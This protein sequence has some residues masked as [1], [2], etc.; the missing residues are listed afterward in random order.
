MI[1]NNTYRLR[2]GLFS[3]NF[4]KNL[5]INQVRRFKVKKYKRNKSCYFMKIVIACW[6]VIHCIVVLS[7]FMEDPFKPSEKVDNNFFARYLHGNIQ[8]Q[9]QKGIINMHLNVRSLRY[10]VNEIK[11]LVQVHSPHI[12]G[13]SEAE[14]TKNSVKE[15][16]LKI[17]GYI[18]YFPKSWSKYGYARVVVYVR[19]SFKCVQVSELEDDK[20]QS[21]WLKGGYAKSKEIFFCHAYREHLSN[22]GSREQQIYLETFLDQWDAACYYGG[23]SEANE[24]HVCGDINID[25]Y[26]GKWLQPNYPLL[27][28][29][30]LIKNFCHANN[31]HQLVENVTRVQYNSVSDITELSCI[32]HVYTNTRF[33]C[34]SPTVI[35]FGDSDHDLVRYIRYSKNPVK[36]T[37]TL[38]TR[39]YKKFKR[40]DFI[41]DVANVDWQDVYSCRDVDSAVEVFTNKF[42]YILNNHA[43][44]VN[45]QQKQNY[46]PWITEETKI[47]MKTRDYWKQV[48]KG[49]PIGSSD[50]I[51]AWQQFKIFRNKVN[52]RKKYE[53]CQ[54]K[55]E[56]M[57]EVSD[58]PDLLWKN[59][60]TF[61]GWTSQGPPQQIQVDNVL[62][63][64]ARKMSQCMN[65]YFVGKV[66]KIRAGMIDAPFPISNL[67][68]FM[69]G[70][71]CK[72]QLRH[73]TLNKVKKILKSL[74]NSRS[75]GVDELDNFSLKIAA[76]FVSQPI[77]HII[78]LSII[79]NKFP[80]NWKFSKV[81]PL[82]KKG[83][84]TDRKNYRPVAIL[85]P[86]SKVVEKI[87][88]EQIYDF[89]TRNKLFHPNLHGYRRNRS[90]QT[91]LLQAYDRWIR[92]A[93]E[94]KLSGV[95]MLDLSAAFDLV[96]AN[97]LLRKLK[98][99]GF[100]SD[101]C[102]WLKSYL[103]NRYQA[104]WIDHVLSD[105]LQCEAGVPQ[106]SNLG[107]LLFLI[108]FNDL[109]LSLNCAF[110]GYADDSTISVSGTTVEEIS[111]NLTENCTTVSNWMKG[112]KLKLNADKTHLLTVGTEARL[113]IQDSCVEVHMDGIKLT[114]SEDRK[115]MLL[116]CYISSNLK[117][118]KNVDYV[119][120]K[121]QLRLTAIRN[122]G[123]K[124]PFGIKC[125]IAEGM[126]TSVLTY[127]LPVFGG[128]NKSDIESLQ[129]MQN[130]AARFVT[131]SEK[132]ANRQEMFL[133]IGWLTVRQLI[134]Y[135]TALCIFRIRDSQEP[136]YL[137]DI[138][139]RN[140]RAN[141]II[142][143]NTC[144]S[145]AKKSFCF[146]G[147]EDWNRLPESVR[148]SKSIGQ[149]KS[150][151]KSWIFRNVAPFGEA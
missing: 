108:F 45:F 137:S 128:C 97:L 77:H 61:M 109:P 113:R 55:A 83:E 115:E 68:D 42:R 91:A 133:Q 123:N 47:L 4:T 130:S 23:K 105:F 147:A 87:V 101:I 38:R 3:L 136:E 7:V 67:K 99:Y 76:D 16:D 107:P 37:R 79:Q 138:L 72:M 132:R 84:K 96:D 40:V 129:I 78:C 135:H 122:L 75:T 18:L 14:L 66:N 41:Q 94:G 119:M 141:K 111:T 49:H 58:S 118:Q 106:G 59:A 9:N 48:A 25:V 31:F 6:V 36:P 93:I 12:F 56:K 143:P 65:E 29:S 52:N 44:W 116:G 102:A 140:N 2:I 19:K 34:S 60:K 149:F 144:L 117:W 80:D 146:R 124:I 150:R 112:N 121:L 70:R 85:S 126:F 95:V 81:I 125:K 11:N 54:Y 43:P 73:V 53:E 134:Q 21:V 103:V 69:S 88:Y 51:E 71:N 110:D 74:S 63:T 27:P 92:A 30:K 90:T 15:E 13:V 98:I 114:E 57:M 104:V 8:N 24:T 148:S 46:Q 62:L 50:Q 35:S 86:V 5:K 17:P 100:E 127:C 20:V 142:I 64:S 39:S 139:L 145:L 28:L 89:F 32:D 26:Q 22:K 120:K 151:L 33:R 10:K 82:H 1:D 131:N